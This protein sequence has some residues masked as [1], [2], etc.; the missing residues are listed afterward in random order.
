MKVLVLSVLC[1]F[2]RRLGFCRRVGWRYTQPAAFADRGL[3]DHQLIGNISD[4]NHVGGQVSI[5][6]DTQDTKLVGK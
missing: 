4:G 1:R 2:M 6:F 5:A 3:K